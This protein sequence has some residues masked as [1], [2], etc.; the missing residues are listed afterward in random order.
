MDV[1]LDNLPKILGGFRDTVLL[2]FA[3]SLVALVLGVFFAALRVSPV[4]V[5]RLAGTTY[6]NVFRNIPLVVLFLITTQ[7]LPELGLSFSF[8]TLA[9]IAL[10]FYTG[11]FICEAIRSGVNSV[12]VGQAEAARSIGMTFTQTL[13]MI[14]LP[15]AIR[16][17]IPPLASILIALTKN[18][19]VAEAFGITEATYQ[20]DSLVRDFPNALYPLFFGISAGYVLIV[21]AIALSARQLERRLVVL[22]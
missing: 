7:G 5:L 10:G 9:V 8:F 21:F 22:R 6:V 4:P 17:V 18:T 11:A 15:Q 3:S 19:A 2:L 16:S 13:G 20:L 1:L 12:D 14:V